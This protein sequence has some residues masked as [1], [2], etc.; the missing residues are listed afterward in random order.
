MSFD[1]LVQAWEDKTLNEHLSGWIDEEL[2][3]DQ[4]SENAKRTYLRS[5]GCSDA[6]IKEM[7]AN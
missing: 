3:F 7:L 4:L 2:Y 5:S 6:D 1:S